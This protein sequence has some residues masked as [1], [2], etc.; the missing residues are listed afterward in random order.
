MKPFILINVK[1]YKQATGTNA[2]KLA[3]ICEKVA[4]KKRVPVIICVQTADISRVASS[5]K[6]PVWAQHVDNIDYGR[7]TGFVLPQSV[8]SAG[9]KGTLLNH[10]EHKLNYKVLAETVKRCRKLKLTTMVCA[11]NKKEAAIVAHYN[12]DFIAIEPPALIGT[13]ISVSTAKPGIITSAIKAVK[14]KAPVVCG[15]G[16]TNGEDVKKALELGTK[17]ALVASAFA[18]AKNPESILKD[19]VRF[20]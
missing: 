17:G 11:A 9:A 13:G 6:I 2:V 10:A 3:K 19:L 12:P 1:T 18:K 8:K 16:I 5:V 15:A 7:N 4:K 14:G 20:I